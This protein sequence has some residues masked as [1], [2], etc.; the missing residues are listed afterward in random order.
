MCTLRRPPLTTTII[1]SVE[2]GLGVGVG[3]ILVPTI[4]AV[5]HDVSAMHL[6]VNVVSSLSKCR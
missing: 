4:R 3:T 6:H 5:R 2:K 1:C